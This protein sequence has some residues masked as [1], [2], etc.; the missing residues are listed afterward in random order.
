V[1]RAGLVMLLLLASATSA[2]AEGKR[3]GVCDP[4]S[5]PG[6]KEK[7][8]SFWFCDDKGAIT[9]NELIRRYERLS[10]SRDVHWALKMR[11][12]VPLILSGIVGAGGIAM[13]VYGFVTLRRPCDANTD[14]GIPDCISP[15]TNMFDASLKVINDTSLAVGAAGIALTLGSVVVATVMARPDGDATDH[16]LSRADAEA[17]VQRYNQIL[18]ERRP[19]AP[20]PPRAQVA[21]YFTGTA[22]GLVGRF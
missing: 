10:G 2:R 8:G 20:A 16:K 19:P 3:V 6:S 18:D 15:T 22:L 7:P 11:N 12:K 17:L 13:V 14:V 1:K 21:P 9:E 5:S 4:S